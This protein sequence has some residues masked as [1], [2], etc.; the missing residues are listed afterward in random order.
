MLRDETSDAHPQ[1]EA[2]ATLEVARAGRDRTQ[3]RVA[4]EELRDRGQLADLTQDAHDLE[5]VL[6]FGDDLRGG[7]VL[8]G[9]LR[10]A[11]QVVGVAL[12]RHQLVGLHADD[13]RPRRMLD[14][15]VVVVGADE[16]REF[17]DAGQDVEILVET[18][19][20]LPLVVTLPPAGCPQGE[21]VSVGESE[22]NRD[23]VSGHGDTA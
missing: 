3:D 7:R 16:G 4:V 6:E 2:L 12:V 8:G 1:V 19:E 14:E 18:E 9:Q 13:G 20:R 10:H 22:L 23:D 17:G 15:V 5:C 11:H 21:A